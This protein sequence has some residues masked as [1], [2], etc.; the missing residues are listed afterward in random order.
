[1]I[2]ET[3]SRQYVF[4]TVREILPVRRAPADPPDATVDQRPLVA[5]SPRRPAP[6]D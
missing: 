2:I 5:S 3:A 4:P 1:M 6:R